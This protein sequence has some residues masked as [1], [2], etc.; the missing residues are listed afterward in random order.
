MTQQRKNFDRNYKLHAACV[1]RE[2]RPELAY[3]GFHGNYAYVNNGQ[4]VVRANIRQISNFHPE[5]YAKLNG[6][7]VHMDNFRRLLNYAV[8]NVTERGF[9]VNDQG[10]RLLIYFADQSTIDYGCEIDNIFDRCTTANMVGAHHVGI[11]ASQM[12]IASAAM[13]ADILRV[14]FYD[15]GNGKIYKHMTNPTSPDKIEAIIYEEV[16][17]NE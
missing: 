10:R 12:R 16:F 8:A 3:I 13:G 6:K 14:G 9:E 11:R 4:M 7:S 15:G 5:D 2:F 17:I 1:L